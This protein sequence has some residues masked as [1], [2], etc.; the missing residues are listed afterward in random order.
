MNI[1]TPFRLDDINLNNIVYKKNINKSDNK[2][3]IF[4]KYNDNNVLKNFVFQ[5]PSLINYNLNFNFV[6]KCVN[7]TKDESLNNFFNNLDN[8]IK[9]DSKKN[10][11][12]WF[13]HLEENQ[14]LHFQKSTIKSDIDNNKLIKLKYI[15]TEEFKTKLLLNNN[16]IEE[17]DIPSFGSCKILLECFAVWIDLDN[18]GIL[19]RPIII[20]YNLKSIFTYNYKLLEDSEEHLSF[21]DEFYEGDDEGSNDDGEEDESIDNETIEEEYASENNEDSDDLFLKNDDIIINIID[22]N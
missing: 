9:S 10:H 18:F 8:K 5:L 15:D 12:S 7:S 1:L 17:N 14:S 6:L 13:D 20:S 21:N 16:E 22:N 11:S 4:I 3:I 2:K 19:L